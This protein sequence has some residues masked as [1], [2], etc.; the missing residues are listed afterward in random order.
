M[1]ERRFSEEEMRAVFARAAER[2]RRADESA[3]RAG[4]S[5]AELQEVASAS[6]IDPA[7]VAAAVAE[8]AA[9]PEPRKTLLGAPVEVTRVRHLAA[10]VSDDAWARIVGELRRAFHDDGVAGQLGRIREWSVVGRGQSSGNVRT[11]LAIEPDGGGVRVMIRRSARDMALGFTIGGSVTALQAIVFAL[12]AAFG[13][14]PEVWIP[15]SILIVLATVFLGGTQVGARVWA[16]QQERKLEALMDRIE[17]IAR[18]DE[19]EQTRVEPEVRASS[20]ARHWTAAEPPAPALD[21]GSSPGLAL[22]ALP[23]EAAPES[24]RPRRRTRS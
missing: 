11:R 6:G 21:P 22:D 16:R 23:D 4:L 1:P 3:G 9:A 12:M 18:E 5:L 20:P 8:M 19:G 15:A 13:G 17:L 24:S 14:D 2:Q 7:H 10:P